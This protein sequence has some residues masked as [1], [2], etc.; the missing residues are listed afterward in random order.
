MLKPIKSNL[1]SFWLIDGKI[2][3]EVIPLGQFCAFFAEIMLL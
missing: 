2:A 1:K 3:D